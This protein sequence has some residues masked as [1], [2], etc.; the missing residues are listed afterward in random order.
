MCGFVSFLCKK[1]AERRQAFPLQHAAADL[2]GS[3]KRV[4]GKVQK[5]PERARA[6]IFR[7]VHNPSHARGDNRA[8]AHWARLERHIQGAVFKKALLPL[9]RRCAQNL[10]LGVGERI[11]RFLAA[12]I[13]GGKDS[14]LSVGQNRADRNLA[15]LR[16]PFRL[17][18]RRAHHGD[19]EFVRHTIFPAS[20]NV[21][22][23]RIPITAQAMRNTPNGEFRSSL[24]ERAGS[25]RYAA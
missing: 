6:G 11:V 8:R 25:T 18:Q 2:R 15:P 12:V 21:S 14:P 19:I 10:R 4:I 17:F 24:T 16:R 1:S 23:V 9:A 22:M 7:A 13:C 5:T 20:I 3:F